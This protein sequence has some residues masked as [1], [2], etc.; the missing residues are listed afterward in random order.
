MS[1]SASNTTSFLIPR[2]RVLP[3]KLMVCE[4]LEIFPAFRGT[5]RF[6][7][8]FTRARHLSLSWATLMQSTPSHPFYFRSVLIHSFHRRLDLRIGL[9]L[10]YRNPV[11]IRRAC[12]MPHPSHPPLIWSH[13]GRNMKMLIMWFSRRQDYTVSEPGRRSLITAC[14]ETWSVGLRMTVRSACGEVSAVSV[15]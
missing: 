10:L 4:L 1:V 2:N 11:C 12:R 5:R 15:W 3:E 7:T 8:M 6:S 13:E 9:M 14:C